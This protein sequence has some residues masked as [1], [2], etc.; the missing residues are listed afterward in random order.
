MRYF[1]HIGYNGYRYRGWQRQPDINNV[2]QVLETA[3]SKILKEPCSIMGCGRTD[4]MVHASQFFF[5]IDVMNPWDFDMQFRLNK[6]LPG[7]I[8][9]FDIL[10][11]ENN[12]HA[13]FDATHRSYDYFIHTYKDPFL[14][15]LSSLYLKEALQLDKMKQAVAL[16]PLYNDYRAF[17]KTPDDYRTTICHV[18]AADL[19]IDANE[20]HLRFHISANRFLGKMIRIIVNKLLDIGRGELSVDEF[21]S[22]LITKITPPTIEPAYPQGLYLSKV[23]YPYLDLPPRADFTAILQNRVEAWKVIS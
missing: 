20:D 10:P 21:E 2:Q 7:D 5:H 6:T 17:C 13:R 3:L 1:F 9:V 12:Q 19:Y 18:T 15:T 11:M 23:T 16:L 8:A 4:A 22:Y 14:S